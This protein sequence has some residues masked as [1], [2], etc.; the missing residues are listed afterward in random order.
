M[1]ECVAA[2]CD[3][4]CC[5]SAFVD[6]GT[7]A[8]PQTGGDCKLRVCDGAGTA[9]TVPDDTDK[10][11]DQDECHA[12]GCSGGSATQAPKP[13]GSPCTVG[14]KVCGD[15]N[16]G[17]A[18]TCVECN[19]AADC[20]A[21][22]VC[23]GNACKGTVLIVAAG[24]SGTIGGEFHP[25]GS[26]VTTSLGG[27]STDPLTIAFTTSGKAVGALRIP[28]TSTPEDDQVWFT[29][30]TAS[31]SFAPFAAINAA[32]VFA[33]AGASISAGDG[34]AQ[35]VFHGT[36]YKHYYASYDGAAWSAAQ[37]LGAQSFGP[38]PASIAALGADAAVVY[39]DGS[40]SPASNK[41]T[42]QDR[43]GAAWQAKAVLDTAQSFT[44]TPAVVAMTA[45]AEVMV[46]YAQSNGALASQT[47]SGGT[48]G[49]PV[50]IPNASISTTSPI[51]PALAALPGGEAMVAFRGTDGFLY[52]S[53]YSAG[54]WSQAAAAFTP[55]LAVAAMPAIARGV[56]TAAVEMALI[57]SDNVAYHA[58]LIGGAWTTPVVVG[59]S[60]LS[61]AAIATAP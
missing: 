5:G 13:A 15:P 23:A 54:A 9:T 49:S 45:G 29:T 47:R 56:G 41:P 20:A 3:M 1:V 24:A 30:W 57:K 43:I 4:G 17:S 10:P 48:W 53:K 58:R 37:A 32:T 44:S 27:R 21:G 36:D 40:G 18:G 22:M 16:G 38:T 46:V 35:L 7:P 34:T 25:G 60:G 12:A 61:T 55:N 2:S 28:K 6:M 50:S 42:A 33:R 8:G 14:G 11:A 39:F 26:W 52:V 51:P 19:T 59:G 31:G